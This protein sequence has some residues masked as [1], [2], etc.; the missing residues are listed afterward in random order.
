MTREVFGRNGKRSRAEDGRGKG[1]KIEDSCVGMGKCR[2][3]RVEGGFLSHSGE[4]KEAFSLKLEIPA[5]R[6]GG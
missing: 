2:G 5:K 1:L 4:W 6:R 3:E